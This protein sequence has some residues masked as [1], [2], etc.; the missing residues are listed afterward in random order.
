M[1]KYRGN[2][3]YYN[4]TDADGNGSATDAGFAVNWFYILLINTL[5][6]LI[7]Y[8][9]YTGLCKKNSDLKHSNTFHSNPFV[10]IGHIQKHHFH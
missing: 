4:G 1:N 7:L 3:L 6:S 8:F 5:V 2:D 9:C 10:A